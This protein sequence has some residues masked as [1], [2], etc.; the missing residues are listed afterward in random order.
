MTRKKSAPAGRVDPPGTGPAL[1]PA[2]SLHW[3]DPDQALLEVDDDEW[4]DA[5]AADLVARE[6]THV[7]DW[8]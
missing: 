8:E 1:P 2:Q 3:P 4:Q 5:Q 6:H 7:H